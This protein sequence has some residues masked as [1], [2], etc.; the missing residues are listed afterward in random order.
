[1]RL[2]E[3]DYH[4]P[5][6][7]IAQTPLPD[8]A[9]SRMLVLHKENG[10]IED[11]HFR[12]LPEYLGPGDCLA[13]NNTRVFPARLFGRKPGYDRQVE[14]FLLKPVSPDRMLWSALARPGRHLHAGSRVD[15]T[16]QLSCEILESGMRGE[17]VIQFHCAG[18]FDAELEAAGH[19]PLPPYIHRPDESG[20][21]ERYQT[22]YAEKRGSVAAPTAGLHFTPEVLAACEERGAGV[23]K[24]TLHVGLATFQPL[25]NDEV[26]A[27]EL[28]EETYEICGANATRLREARRIVAVGTTSV[29][30]IESAALNGGLEPQTGAT[31]LFIYPGFEFKATGAMLTN[32]HLPKSSLLLLVSAFAGPDYVLNAYRYAVDQRYR[33][34]SYGDCML[35]V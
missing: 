35:I 9:S 15:F 31:R 19:V 1:M 14:I 11:R 32:F 29:R 12:D 17:R 13:L 6:E 16:E 27:N 7:L 26:A 21:R 33:F 24:V 4:L 5:D 20:D 10:R 28:H 2:S 34:F 8:R 30:T 22:V 25:A 3:F 23:A 18:D